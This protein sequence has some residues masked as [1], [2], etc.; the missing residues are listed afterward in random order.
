VTTK[1]FRGA[2]GGVSDTAV[3]VIL[4]YLCWRSVARSI[5]DLGWKSKLLQSWKL[6]HG[7]VQRSD[8]I[9]PRQVFLYFIGV[10]Q[11]L[12]RSNPPTKT[13]SC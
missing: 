4:S 11:D 7:S 13:S 6:K 9:D 3:V 10:K 12:M 8:T 2:N 1:I 5:S